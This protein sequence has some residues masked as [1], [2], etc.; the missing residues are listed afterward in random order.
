MEVEYSSILVNVALACV[1]FAVVWLLAFGV[2]PILEE[3]KDLTTEKKNE[4]FQRAKTLEAAIAE[5]RSL[6]KTLIHDVA[7]SIDVQVSD[8]WVIST[9]NVLS[10][11]LQTLRQ[12]LPIK[13][14]RISPEEV[15]EAANQ[16]AGFVKV[17]TDNVAGNLPNIENELK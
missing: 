9:A 12:I 10:E 17:L 11:G 2:L 8:P 13:D 4:V 1:S 15:A 14:E 3:F 16:V 7:S 5:N 6:P